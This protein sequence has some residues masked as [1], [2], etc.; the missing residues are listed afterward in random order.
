MTDENA[1]QAHGE[2]E[3]ATPEQ[4]KG[5]TPEM[6]EERFK[7]FATED[8]NRAITAHGKRQEATIKD[9]VS[10][11][12]TESRQAEREQQEQAGQSAAEVEKRKLETRMQT[13]EKQLTVDGHMSLQLPACSD[14]CI[15]EARYAGPP[16]EQARW[17][18]A[19]LSAVVFV[20]GLFWYDKRLLAR[21]D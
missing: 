18:A 11:V 17:I 16:G 14:G 8:L 7:R 20:G 4:S 15:I 6:L 3:A 9:I 1:E 5:V 12:L 13:L 19:V 2:Q 10:Q 21:R